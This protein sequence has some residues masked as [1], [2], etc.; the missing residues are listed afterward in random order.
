MA[1]T[2][3][4]LECHNFPGSSAIGGGEARWQSMGSNSVYDRRKTSDISLVS[5]QRIGR[6]LPRQTP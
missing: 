4:I 2:F 6:H 1:L 3:A 5:K